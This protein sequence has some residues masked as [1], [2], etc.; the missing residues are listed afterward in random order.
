M[1]REDAVAAGIKRA[2]TRIDGLGEPVSVR[3]VPASAP[4]VADSV[5]I[6]LKAVL[7]AAT[8]GCSRPADV[9]IRDVRDARR[10]RGS[11]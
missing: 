5:D 2:G 7:T 8:F 4:R 3:G 11:R 6:V 1:A 9:G 10:S